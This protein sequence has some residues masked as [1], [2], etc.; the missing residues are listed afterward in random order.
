[1]RDRDGVSKKFTT[2]DEGRRAWNEQKRGRPARTAAAPTFL[3]PDVPVAKRQVSGAR[4]AT[5][6]LI[7][8]VNFAV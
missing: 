8:H 4:A 1:M 6:R 3:V 5:R 7:L 2:D